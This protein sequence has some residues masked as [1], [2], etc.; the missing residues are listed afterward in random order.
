MFKS[1]SSQYYPEHK[2]QT[3]AA[4]ENY[5]PISFVDIDI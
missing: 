4:K 1:I 2:S 3:K 5:R